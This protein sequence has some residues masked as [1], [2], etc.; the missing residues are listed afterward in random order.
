MKI[1]FF[2]LSVC[3]LTHALWAQ[4][5]ASW[6]A[7]STTG[8]Y[9]DGANWSTGVMP[10]NAAVAT[11]SATGSYTISAPAGGLVEN[12]AFFMLPNNQPLSV[13]LDTT[14]TW[15][16]KTAANYPADWQAFGLSPTASI[17]QHIFNM[18]SVS[19][20]ADR[21]VFFISNAV[22]RFQCNS[23]AATNTFESGLFDFSYKGETN[24]T[25]ANWMISGYGSPSIQRTLF[26]PGSRTIFGMLS[27]RGSAADQLTAFEGGLHEFYGRISVK[28][29]S[30]N[31]GVPDTLLLFT[32]TS[33]NLL[34]GGL[35]LCNATG[36]RGILRMEQTAY[37]RLGNADAGAAT[38]S[39][40]LLLVTNN[41]VAHNMGGDITLGAA[42]RSRGDLVLAG[43]G[44][45]RSTGY[46]VIKLAAGASST[47]LLTVAEN[48]QMSLENTQGITIGMN[49]NIFA[50]MA[51]KDTAQVTVSGAAVIA[52]GASAATGSLTLANSALL[53]MPGSGN[54]NL[55][56]AA[57]SVGVLSLK[58]SARLTRS[59][60]NDIRIGNVS[61]GTGI[62]NVADNSSITLTSNSGNITLAGGN[63]AVGYLNITSNATLSMS[64]VLTVGANSYGYGEVN[65]DGNAHMDLGTNGT[66]SIA[67]TDNAVGVFNLNGNAT[68]YSG[69]TNKYFH[70]GYGNGT[71]AS[72]NINGGVF[73]A[74]NSIV[75]PYAFYGEINLAGGESCVY[76]YRFTGSG[77]IGTTN[78]L[79]VTGGRHI[80]GPAGMGMGNGSNRVDV[81]LVT[82]AGGEL[83]SEKNGLALG[84]GVANLTVSP[85]QKLTVSGGRF[86]VGTSAI[87]VA[88]SNPSFGRVE[89][90][91]GELEAAAIYG[92]AGAI[93]QG[94]SGYASFLGDGGKIIFSATGSNYLARLDDARIGNNGLEIVNSTLASIDQV[95]TNA[96]GANGQIIK[97]GSGILN[98]L[99]TSSHTATLIHAGEL[100]L[101]TGV[102][103]FG[104]N[105]RLANSASLNALDNL[106]LVTLT[107]TNS[108]IRLAAGKKI[109]ADTASLSGLTILTSGWDLGSYDLIEAPTLSAENITI[110]GESAT[111]VYTVSVTSGKVTLTVE[112][113]PPAATK[114]W[115]GTG[116][117]WNTTENWSGGIPAKQDMAL[118]GGADPKNVSVDSATQVNIIQFNAANSYTLTGEK[119]TVFTGI[120]TVTG[121]HTISTPIEVPDATNILSLTAQTG[122]K[123]T[124]EGRLSEN[125][126]ST[127][128]K[129]EAGTVRIA[130][131]NSLSGAITVEGGV[132]DFGSSQSF[133]SANSSASA[134]TLKAGS[135]R[136]S[137]APATATKGITMADV[138]TTVTNAFV[139]DIQS[140]LMLNAAIQNTRGAPIKT[141][142]GDL[143]VNFPAAG[144]YMIASS[145]GRAIFNSTPLQMD[146]IPSTGYSGFTVVEGG[147][148]F[149]GTSDMTAQMPYQTVIGAKVR[150]TNLTANAALTI[151]GCKANIGGSGEHLFVG[152]GINTGMPNKP[153]LNVVN[154]GYILINA[155]KTSGDANAPVDAQINVSNRG[156]I[157][158][159]WAI[160]FGMNN[161]GSNKTTVRMSNGV[162]RCYGT[163]DFSCGGPLDFVAGSGSA[164]TQTCTAG[165]I[166]RSN[167]SGQM[168]FEG[169]SRF[170]YN[171]LRFD[172]NVGANLV[173]QFDNAFLQ[174]NANNTTS[175]TVRASGLGFE[176][177]AGGVTVDMSSVARHVINLPIRGTGGLIKTGTG[178]LV[179]G[180][181]STN[182]VIGPE[183]TAQYTGLTDIRTGTL[184]VETNGV[185]SVTRVKVASGATLNLSNS[186]ITLGTVEG[187]GVITNG[188]LTSTLKCT[189]TDGATQADA[190][191]TFVNVNT[192]GFKVD[193]GRST[194]NPVT[195]ATPKLAV[196]KVTGSTLPDVSMWRGQNMGSRVSAVF[197]IENT[198]VY[199]TFDFGG[200]RLIIR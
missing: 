187:D 189:F 175:R 161:S 12:S 20:A 117:S 170:Y 168:R 87:R 192:S 81:S 167:S 183:I 90:T 99:K 148:T 103:Q 58:D 56:T 154:G 101:G 182:N 108:T 118:F 59:N 30:P 116:T 93:N 109:M 55:G 166:F 95:F 15:W 9:N 178:E 165:V 75:E 152:Y 74:T 157:D 111:Q 143:T 73:A 67:P 114:T 71:R 132:L 104:Q 89:L 17:G 110:A 57:G 35:Q 140:N 80:V 193:F 21:N 52:V 188:T 174:P 145:R 47:G 34:Y 169:G 82:V 147:V 49:T 83:I 146:G 18:E 72:L 191:P 76:E 131:T 105:M 85:I 77:A 106:S 196:A 135:F 177:L 41:A 173:V 197:S 113:T 37:A 16:K 185:G 102:T 97:N 164:V 53:N 70:P 160:Q 151:D 36:N 129:S 1:S 86:S 94:G 136:Y 28:C 19:T 155:L 179:L 7:S 54:L 33:S 4:G 2:M 25:S 194:D 6:N 119:L 141:G 44:Y 3:L 123:L 149:K 139:F 180:T 39:K 51:V 138:S 68:F 190:Q 172:N 130:G 134:L 199:A 142:I 60:A 13:T 63:N 5:N 126:S 43:N 69:V 45:Y 62:V 64:G 158:S 92:S 159:N 23:Q 162:M 61:G 91:G 195:P 122:T 65:L 184:T 29:D 198:T 163:G 10:T 176:L 50:E 40:G 144:S 200:T 79:T 46:G 22:W 186:P 150:G 66:V 32:G 38:G 78:K 133:G 127:L 96:D 48:A 88:N 98:I 11:L 107:A 100:K 121:K 181:G 14:G 124:L 112:A 26:K 42:T 128:T 171:M 24:R 120:E 27:I 156:F 137:G 31:A 115:Q 153:A 125:Q 84:I 8:Y